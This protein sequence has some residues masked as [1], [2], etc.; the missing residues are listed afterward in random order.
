M[1]G[2]G[3][4][5]VF[6]ALT[7]LLSQPALG[8]EAATGKAEAR[9]RFQ[10]GLILAQRGELTAAIQ[11]FEAAYATRPHYSV[12]YNIAQAQAALGRSVE[13][14]STFERY[15]G[16]GGG[17]ISDA[18]RAEVQAAIDASRKSIGKLKLTL[19]ASARNRTRV[20]L[21]G[22]ELE[23]KQLEEPLTLSAGK[24]QLLYSSGAGYPVTEEIAVLGAESTEVRID[25]PADSQLE[26][27]ELHVICQVPGVVVLVDGVA[28]ATT[29]L[30]RRLATGSGL[31]RVGFVRP[32]YRALE[33]VITVRPG[34]I[35]QVDCNARIE[36]ALAA[37]VRASLRVQTM[38]RDA[39]IWLNGQTFTA[40]P[41]PLGPHD[42]RVVREGYLA[43]RRTISL[44]AGR[45]QSHEVVLQPT[46]AKRA[47]ADAAMS[48]RKTFSYVLGG[49]GLALLATSGGVLLWNQNRYDD[50]RGQERPD[51]NRVA[52]IQRADD[53]SLGLAIL[54][55]GLAVGGAWTFFT[56]G[57]NDD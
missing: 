33:Q 47:R 38:P 43:Y 54:G 25:A 19:T 13:A 3:F 20:W 41:V 36:R 30:A 5:L 4:R 24:H 50:W 52:S 8:Q 15:L 56:S 48:R 6:G 35:S 37:G 55:T 27:G 22:V 11:A 42:L 9:L 28:T 29:P 49:A 14:V 32:G 18:R 26:Q 46:P 53:L 12:L 51:L 34:T 31:H 45:H 7:L 21:D 23:S 39:R 57:A 40:G 44:A 17:Q 2:F 16:E 1:Q 10:E